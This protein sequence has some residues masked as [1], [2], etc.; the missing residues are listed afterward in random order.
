MPE[1]L[2]GP[3][4]IRS[5]ASTATCRTPTGRRQRRWRSTTRAITVRV[6]PGTAIG[7][8]ARVRAPDG[9]EVI[10][11]TT[12]VGQDR[13][14][15]GTLDFVPVWG[16]DT[17]VLRGEYPIS[18]PA[19]TVTASDPA[20][21][22]R[23]A[24]APA[25]GARRG[26][27]DRSQVA[28]P[29]QA[30]AGGRRARARCSRNTVR[31]PLAELLAPILTDSHNWYTDMLILTLGREV[32]ES[33]RFEDGVE[34]VATFLAGLP[35]MGIGAPREP[36]LLDGSGLSPAN[37]VT[38]RTVVRLLA[39]AMRQPWS[40]TMI[41]ALPGPGEGTLEFWPR[42]PPVA[43]KTGTLRHTVALA[44]ILDPDS[45]APVVFCYFI[46]HHPEQRAAARREIADALRRWQAPGAAR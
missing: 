42:L 43:A 14:G 18:E 10:N 37:L 25:A 39:Y 13:H 12:T 38:P 19:A 35:D 36:W 20:P 40:R 7:R 2:P 17:L 45:G 11:H 26:G 1:P 16:T 30:S 31:P 44:G 21:A 15:S 29:F 32:A 24:A 5:I 34:V 22:R 41:E 9:I 28:S 46:N 3:A 33:G 23:A 4:G 27:S 6:A 8:P